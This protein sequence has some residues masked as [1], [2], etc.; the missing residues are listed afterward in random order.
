MKFWEFA[1]EYIWCWLWK[2][3]MSF[4]AA[5]L[6]INSY[7]RVVFKVCYLDVFKTKFPLWAS[8]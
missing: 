5:Y 6:F 4:T 8:N 7:I 2:C 1:L 3:G